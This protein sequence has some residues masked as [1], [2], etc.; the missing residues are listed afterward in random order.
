MTRAV[1]FELSAD[2]AGKVVHVWRPP[3]TLVSP[4]RQTLCRD[5]NRVLE[6]V[7]DG[8]AEYTLTGDDQTVG[9]LVDSLGGSTV[10]G[11]PEEV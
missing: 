7:L 6:R 2:E 11:C 3:A 4:T 1:R 10:A 5:G 8:L 9:P